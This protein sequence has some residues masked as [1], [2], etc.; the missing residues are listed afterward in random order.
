MQHSMP[1]SRRIYLDHSATTPLAPDVMNC[2]THHL[3][4]FGNPSSIHEFGEAARDQVELA[5][6]HVARLL[7]VEADE[8]IFTS[9]GSESLNL[10]IKGVVATSKHRPC[11]VITSQIE[12]AAVL[13]TC[14]HLEAHGHEVTYLPV[15]SGGLV[16]PDAVRRNLRPHTQLISVMHANNEI[17]VIQPIEEIGAIAHAAGIPFHTD[18]V[19]TVGKR[20]INVAMLPIDLLSLTAHKFYG[21]KGIGALIVRNGTRIQ[22]LIHGGSQETGLRAGTENVLGI[23]GLGA[24]CELAYH[25]LADETWQTHRQR[26]RDRL[27]EGIMQLDGVQ[28]NGDLNHTVHGL[29]NVSFRGIKGDA[30]ASALAFQ[31]IAVSTGSAC[32]ASERKASHVMVALGLSD[33][34]RYS[35]IRFSLGNYTT[36]DEID[37]TIAV[38]HQVVNRLRSMLPTTKVI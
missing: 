5:R 17:G 23:I 28:V 9:G 25:E 29:L 36:A 4:T 38:V 20:P 21:P 8:V 18:A 1:S 11:H 24:A 37:Q 7:S 30:I 6:R 32:H 14:R 15:S 12:H 34:W 26:L 35:T 27:Y 22:P 19:Q 31:G 3:R 10:A 16:D 13:E 33:E 2:M